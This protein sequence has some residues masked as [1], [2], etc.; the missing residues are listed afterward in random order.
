MTNSQTAQQVELTARNLVILAVG[1]VIT[2]F[3]ALGSHDLA[4]AHLGIPYPSD[5]DVPPWARFLGQV[6]RLG[7]MVYVCRL[8]RWYLD[9]RST[10]LAATIFGLLIVLLQETL[11]V[12]VVDNIVSDGW[13]D[14]RWVHLLM[15]RLPN[16]LLSFYSGAIAVVIARKIGSDRH[17]R[18]LIAI[19]VASAI[20][21]FGL[22]PALTAVSDLIT[23]ALQLTEVPE[24]HTMPY[25]IYVYKYIYGMFIEPTISSFALIYLLW[26]ALNGSKP[27]RIAIFVFLMLL[28]R[29]R[30]IATGLFSFW[31]KDSWALAFAAE[32]QF[33]IETL[34]LAALTG[35]TWAAITP[36]VTTDGGDAS[37][38]D[39]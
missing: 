36:E 11:R 34:I 8:A 9:K 12:I 38:H 30:V 7:A 5:G 17:V 16:A 6:V 18:L 33:F 24:V 19:A 28:M 14:L 2:A 27:R 22:L 13:I 37:S 35:L 1:L 32:G 39:R 29:G 25:G 23:A 26:P 15:N 31:I 20:G 4:I 3:L 10:V 21:Y